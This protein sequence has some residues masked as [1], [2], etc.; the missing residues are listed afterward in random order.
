MINFLVR[1]IV[2]AKAR[3]P[4]ELLVDELGVLVFLMWLCLFLFLFGTGLDVDH[5]L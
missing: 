1:L 3:H 2:F 5:H 4:H